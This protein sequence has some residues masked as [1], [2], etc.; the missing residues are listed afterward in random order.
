MAAPP[1]RIN[2]MLAGIHNGFCITPP[3]V[4]KKPAD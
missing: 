3:R 4:P 2:N 1:A